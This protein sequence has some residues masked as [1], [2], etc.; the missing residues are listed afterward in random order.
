[1]KIWNTASGA[2]T[3]VIMEAIE[4]Y[5]RPCSLSAEGSRIAV[6]RCILSD[7]DHNTW[8]VTAAKFALPGQS[9]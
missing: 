8:P 6:I 4:H 3:A 5:D 1:M 7:A 9:S 2:E